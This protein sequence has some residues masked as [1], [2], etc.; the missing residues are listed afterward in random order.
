MCVIMSLVAELSSKNNT[1]EGIKADL[2]IA[3]PNMLK[4][5]RVIFE[6]KIMNQINFKACFSYLDVFLKISSATQ[7]QFKL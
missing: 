2:E 1:V 3:I 7:I 4:Y 5:F 6:S